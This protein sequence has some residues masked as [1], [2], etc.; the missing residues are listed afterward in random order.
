MK[1]YQ[2]LKEKHLL[3]LLL[4]ST[5]TFNA[6]GSSQDESALSII[7]GDLVKKDDPLVDSVVLLLINI[8]YK[9]TESDIFRSAFTGESL[10]KSTE[11]RCTGTVV[12]N[13]TDKSKWHVVTAAHCLQG[14]VNSVEIY[15]GS[16]FFSAFPNPTSKE[17]AL[18]LS[19]AHSTLVKERGEE[20]TMKDLGFELVAKTSV[21][22]N[23]SNFNDR[24]INLKNRECK[25][26]RH[27]GL[28]WERLAY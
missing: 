21:Y 10:P 25:E 28:F 20:L 8:E 3:H 16:R 12:K 19:H 2:W 26:V 24:K 5:M 14:N 1:Y 27:V 6:C 22:S 7:G 4:A 13:P 11:G 23:H 15:K 18:S 17:E 9:P